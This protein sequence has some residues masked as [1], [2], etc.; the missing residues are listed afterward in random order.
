VRTAGKLSLTN[1]RTG[2]GPAVKPAALVAL[3]AYQPAPVQSST[4]SC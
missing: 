2:D 4:E 1:I 3:S